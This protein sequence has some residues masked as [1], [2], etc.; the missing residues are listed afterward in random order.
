MQ[1]YIVQRS[2]NAIPLSYPKDMTDF[3]T[4]GEPLQRFIVGNNNTYLGSHVKLPIFLPNF[5]QIWTF[6]TNFHKNPHIIFNG[7][8]PSGNH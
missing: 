7:N 8:Q 4:K 1:R 5:G 6:S 2:C 3:Y